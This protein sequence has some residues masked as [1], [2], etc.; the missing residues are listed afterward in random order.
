MPPGTEG[1]CE[2]RPPSKRPGAFIYE[3]DPNSPAVR[4]FGNEGNQDALVGAWAKRAIRAQPGDYLASVWQ[5]ARAYWVPSRPP[6]HREPG[7]GL[8]PQL[9][10]SYDTFY[11]P[12]IHD[13][14][15]AFYKPFTEHR[16][17][18]LLDALRSLQRVGRFGATLLSIATLLTLIG[19]FVGT[20][21]SRCAVFL[22]GVGGLSLL[23]TAALTGN[24]SGR[25]TVPMAGPMLTA[26]AIT[27]V[28]LRRRLARP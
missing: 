21:R 1:L 20:R 23:V 17:L 5:H 27:L 25:Y 15:E 8:D 2:K 11:R 3:T 4:L 16:R 19:L 26:G 18:G 28:A 22:F 13:R 6:P 24:Y 9:D 10:I 7:H 14:L 12:L